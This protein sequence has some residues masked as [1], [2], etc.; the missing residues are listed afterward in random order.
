MFP[1]DAVRVGIPTTR[2][3]GSSGQYFT[4]ASFPLS[5]TSHLIVFQM[6]HMSMKFTT[7]IKC[8]IL[9]I[10]FG[11]IAG[12]V[13]VALSIPAAIRSALPDAL[14]ASTSSAALPSLV[15]TSAIPAISLISV[16]R[17]SSASIL[18]PAFLKRRASAV[19]TVY[20]KPQG[21]SF[22]DRLLGP[23]RLLGRAV[24]LTSDGWFVT[25]FSVTDGL[26]AAELLIWI[27]G[28]SYSIERGVI[29]HVNGTV[30]LKTRAQGLLSPSFIQPR[31]IGNGAD[32]WIESRPNG[33]T[34]TIIVDAGARA[35][36]ND[37][38]SSEVAIRRFA[39]NRVSG[40]GERGSAAWDP[41][42][43]LVGL[44]ESRD[45]EETRLLPASSIAS[46]FESLLATG[47]IRHAMLGVRTLDLVALRVSGARNGLPDRGALVRD[48]KRGGKMANA[49][50]KIGDVIESV[51]RDILDG[52]ADLG[53]ILAE[54][55]PNAEVTLRILRDGKT[56]DVPETLGSIL[57]SEA[58]K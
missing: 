12:S 32:V 54:Y 57:T 20:R 8:A 31:G 28:A 43:A 49:K 48:D 13:T 19:A 40:A 18:P 37:A 9:A 22:E 46:S 44:I 47:D 25:F 14:R 55:K 50:I 38:G 10:A 36:P 58:M 21:T 16:D 17:P 7:E 6:F 11:A 23:E 41:T 29:D 2:Y 5:S 30:F 56:L 24:A 51:D 4:S 53:E 35:R 45:G 15:A 42:G 39:L 1:D 33:F 27:N 26:R 52:R 3:A 34:P